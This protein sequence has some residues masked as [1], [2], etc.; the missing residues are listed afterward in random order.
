[1]DVHRISEI[2]DDSFG[3]QPAGFLFIRIAAF[4]VQQLLIANGHASP[5]D[6][7]LAVTGVNVIEIG[8]RGVLA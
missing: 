2:T 3:A 5:A 8:Q 7:V 1:V 4:G 6:P